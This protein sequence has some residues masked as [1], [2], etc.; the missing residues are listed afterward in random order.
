LIGEQEQLSFATLH[1]RAD[2]LARRLAALG[3]RPG[4]VV[5]IALPREPTLV[6][7]VLAVHKAGGAYLPLDPSYPPERIKFMVADSAAPVIVTTAELAP[8]FSDSGAQLLL[9]TELVS[10]GLE[11]AEPISAGPGDLAYVF[12]TSGSTGR[13]KA[14]GIEHRNIVNLISWGRSVVS[15]S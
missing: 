11:L 10:P 4:I 8:S 14:V 7:A 1:E 6:I 12:Y 13:P 5:G 9:D 15:D 2:L 3:V